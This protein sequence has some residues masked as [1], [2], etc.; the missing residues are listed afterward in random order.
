MDEITAKACINILIRRV[1]GIE[2][3]YLLGMDM[4]GVTNEIFNITDTETPGAGRNRWPRFRSCMGF[5]GAWLIKLPGNVQ[6]IRVQMIFFWMTQHIEH[7]PQAQDPTRRQKRLA[8]RTFRPGDNNFAV[9]QGL[10]KI[11]GGQTD[12]PF[13]LL[14]TETLSHGPVEPR[15][16]LGNGRP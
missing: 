13:R 12:F 4:V 5:E 3:Q 7:G 9:A 16:G 1:N 15:A 10:D 14:Q 11:M 8:R 6:I 2:G